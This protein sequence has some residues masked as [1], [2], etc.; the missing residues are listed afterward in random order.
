MMRAIMAGLAGGAFGVGLWL[1]GMTD[2]AKVQGWLDLFG[3]W[4][5]TLTFVMGGAI[6]PMALAWRFSIGRRPVLGGSFPKR[7]GARFDPALIGGSVLF[8]I[9]WGLTGFCPGPA[10]ASVSWGGFGGA[11]FLA[12]MLI[13]MWVAPRLR[14]RLDGGAAR[15]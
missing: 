2:T 4:D 6:V 14:T 10:I 5:P 11:I 9:G 13:G 8:G 12:A 3:V 15:V 7:P 1:S